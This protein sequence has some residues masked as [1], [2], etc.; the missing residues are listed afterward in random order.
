MGRP[1]QLSQQPE[2]QAA[3]RS[4]IGTR[5]AV[6]HLAVNLTAGKPPGTSLPLRNLTGS[7]LN[8]SN[9]PISTWP[10]SRPAAGAHINSHAFTVGPA[11]RHG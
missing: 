8:V 3:L 4:A 11:G 5:P 2:R 6:T 7:N 1:A 10:A 9:L